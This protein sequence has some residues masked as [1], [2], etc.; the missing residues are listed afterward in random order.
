MSRLFISHSSQDKAEVER[1][2]EFLVL[3]MDV[4]RQDIFCT[5][6]SGTLPVGQ[7]FIDNIR[8]ALTD[9]NL[10]LCFLTPNYLQSKF[11]LAELGAAWIQ[12]GKILPLI[13]APL[14][15]QNLNDTPL[16]DLQMLSLENPEDLTILY[17][18]LTALEIARSKQTVVFTK[19]LQRYL[20]SAHQ[21]TV[22]SS[23]PVLVEPDENG[24]YH[25]RITDIR[26]VPSTYRCY[27]LETPIDLHLPMVP[28]ETHW[29]FYQAGTYADLVPGDTIRFMVH[30][31]QLRDF[32]DLKHARNIYPSDLQK[33]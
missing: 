32:P 21:S 19:Y 8:S 18:S 5:S 33:Y 10:V 14:Q 4:S 17:D 15:F 13:K 16:R 23:S 30:S 7:P 6:Q 31:S 22:L 3:G 28:G 27:K 11:C 9:C 12:K 20:H 29:I 24:Y 26:N 1:F 2:I 25:V